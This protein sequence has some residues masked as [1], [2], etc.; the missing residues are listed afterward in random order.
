MYAR[1]RWTKVQRLETADSH[2]DDVS[3]ALSVNHLGIHLAT[4]KNGSLK[5]SVPVF[6]AH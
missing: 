4:I 6:F 5:F 3:F 2:G 1:S